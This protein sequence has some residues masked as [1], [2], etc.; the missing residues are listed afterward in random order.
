MWLAS[1]SGGGFNSL[2]DSKGQYDF[3]VTVNSSS[4]PQYQCRVSIQ[5]RS[6]EVT[7]EVYDGP[8]TGIET[9]GEI[10]ILG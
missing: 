3:S 2:N 4:Q 8:R 5:H 6:D 1:N 7:T 9:L 10:V